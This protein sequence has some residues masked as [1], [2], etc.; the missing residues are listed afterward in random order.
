MVKRVL[1]AVYKEIRG[2]HQAA[3]VLALF[4]FGSQL[5]ALVRDRILAHQFGA[6]S[7]LD[8]YYAAFRIPDLLFVLFASTLSVY[9]LIPFIAS[10]IDKTGKESA[11]DLLSQVFTLF[12]IFYAVLA[13]V[14]AFAAPLLVSILFPGFTESQAEQLVILMRILLLQPMFLGISSLFGVITQLGHRFV[15]YALSPLLYNVGIIIGIIFLFP[16]VG[17]KGIAF[18]V[19]LG[20]IAH[21]AVQ[22]PFVRGSKLVPH[23]TKNLRRA[24]LVAILRV[25]IPRA[26]TL[27]IHQIVFLVFVGIASVMAVGSVSVFQFAFNLQSVPLAIIGVSY[28]VAAF[29]TLAQLF[30][31]G[32]RIA[33]EAQITSALRHIIFWSV[34]AMVLIIV[35]R[36]HIVRV[37]LGTGA[38]DWEDTRLTAAALA[39]FSVS[40]A[41]Q[42]VNLLMIRAFYACNNTKTPLIVTLA[43]SSGMLVLTLVLYVLFSVSPELV[44]GLEALMRVEGVAG[45]EVLVLAF[46]YTIGLIVHI[47]TLLFVFQKIQRISF[48]GLRESFVRSLAASLLGG[49]GAYIT[50][51]VLVSGLRTET[52]IGIFLQGALAGLVGLTLIGV[53]LHLQGSPELKEVMRAFHRRIFKTDVVH[54]K[55]LD[56]LAG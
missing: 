32:N 38:F 22:L 33:F 7:E 3:Y 19:V 44:R 30:S 8:I 31:K 9:V 28:S 42:A 48:S 10:R 14:L 25:S 26:L 16:I 2:L 41:A 40:L 4:T 47:V 35:E 53:A 17:L 29:P 6:G 27:S 15:L 46:G 55:E 52:F 34:P 50:L 21:M 13:V 18:G 20:A 54:P 12:L 24:D 39:I 51:N 5:L 37:I 49:V 23:I 45:S 43:T 1:Q 36:A 11:R 56:D